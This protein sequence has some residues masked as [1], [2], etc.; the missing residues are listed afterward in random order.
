MM[1][2]SAIA[3]MLGVALAAVL[4][5]LAIPIA[6]RAQAGSPLPVCVQASPRPAP[7]PAAPECLPAALGGP[8]ALILEAN[9]VGAAA[10]WWCA[11][12]G[13]RVALK[14]YAVRWASMT[15]G[16]ALDAAALGL[17]GDN[18]ARIKAMLERHQTGS[19]LD[20]CDVWGPIRD[21]I[22]AAMP[23]PVPAPPT[24]SWVVAR[25]SLQPTRPAYPV[26]A[27]VRGTAAAAQRAPVGA[28]CDCTSPIA[29]GPVTYC[30]FTGGAP[31]LV[32][33]CARQP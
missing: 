7:A 30:P 14:L 17:P 33:A 24:A 5:M 12:P 16:M 18:A 10:A 26:T 28:A 1:R 15:P 9:S 22:N 25:F 29:E 27:G 13:G 4:V 23:A 19:S 3:V 11:P 31:G 6:A 21:R 20:M 2:R 8:G 32:T